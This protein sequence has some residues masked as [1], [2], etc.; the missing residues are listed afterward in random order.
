[1]GKIRK[2]NLYKVILQQVLTFTLRV[3]ND[4][5]PSDLQ[6]KFPL[7]QNNYPTDFSKNNYKEPKLNLRMTQFAM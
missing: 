2:L 6:E 1:M 4:T 5:I 7:R 3:K